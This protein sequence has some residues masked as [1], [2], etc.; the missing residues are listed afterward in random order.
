ML[1]HETPLAG[2]PDEP[3]LMALL[4]EDYVAHG[5]RPAAPGLHALVVHRLGAARLR[6]Q[7]PLARAPFSLLYRVIARGIAS[8]YGIELSASAEI[9]R[10]VV[11]HRQHGIVV[12]GRV[13]IGDDCVIQHDVGL[14]VLLPSHGTS[15]ADEALVLGCGVHVGPGAQVARGIRLGNG[16]SIEANAVVLADVPAGRIAIGVP[17]HLVDRRAPERA[18]DEQA[19]DGPCRRSTDDHDLVECS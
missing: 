9:G 3:G 12:S 17:A 13:V 8:L 15:S 19:A 10:R 6:I 7:P 18:L 14:G 16:A 2:R 1:S 5:R 4:V 11:F